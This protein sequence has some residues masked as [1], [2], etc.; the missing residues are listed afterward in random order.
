MVRV[1]LLCNKLCRWVFAIN[2]KRQHR[3]RR[4][5]GVAVKQTRGEEGRDLGLIFLLV[6]KVIGFAWEALREICQWRSESFEELVRMRS[7]LDL[8]Y[9]K[10]WYKHVSWWARMIGQQVWE[11][12]VRYQTLNYRL[13][14]ERGFDHETKRAQTR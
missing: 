5:E 11:K 4:S 2:G 6:E 13:F 7:K 8:F 1:F 10:R 14:L 12:R 3:V 9:I